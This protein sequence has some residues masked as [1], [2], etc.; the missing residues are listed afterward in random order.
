MHRSWVSPPEFVPPKR[1]PYARPAPH[2]QSRRAALSEARRWT[3]RART[4]TWKRWRS[5]TR[6]GTAVRLARGER[7]S[8]CSVS[9]DAQL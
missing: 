6:G 4:G 3:L 2:L 8:V 5:G 1:K 9:G 7:G